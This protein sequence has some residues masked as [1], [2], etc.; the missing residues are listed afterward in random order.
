MFK[1]PRFS[2]EVEQEQIKITKC[3]VQLTRRGH[4]R[5]AGWRYRSNSGG[6]ELT[7]EASRSD[8]ETGERERERKN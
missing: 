3:G 2:R 7:M 4:S 6:Q 1:D 5:T 8:E